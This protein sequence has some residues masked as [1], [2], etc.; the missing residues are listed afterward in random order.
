MTEHDRTA[1]TIARCLGTYYKKG[2]GPDIITNDCVIEVATVDEIY[3][4]FPKLN[5]FTCDVYIAG[6][7]PEAT[8]KIVNEVA[9]TSVGAMNHF[10]DILIESTN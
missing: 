1:R 3:D 2:K 8:K 9:G 5:F 4:A 7:N 10:G 6:A